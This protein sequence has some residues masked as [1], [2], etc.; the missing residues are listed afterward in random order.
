MRCIDSIPLWTVDRS[1]YFLQ[2]CILSSFPEFGS[3]G[4]CL[5]IVVA[6]PYCWSGF[7]T[8]YSHCW[9]SKIVG[10]KACEALIRES[11]RG[12]KVW[13]WRPD[14]TQSSS[15]LSD[16]FMCSRLMCSSQTFWAVRETW[17]HFDLRVS[18]HCAARYDTQWCAIFDRVWYNASLEMSSV[19]Y[20]TLQISADLCGEKDTVHHCSHC[21]RCGALSC[22]P[23]PFQRFSK[24]LL[25]SWLPLS[26]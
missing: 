16:R 2:G 7:E 18:C 20:V 5:M 12:Q 6:F 8:L 22:S 21:K 26:A 4:R 13:M 3:K 24:T 1:G 10:C 25:V 9:Q 23:F 11:D 19:Y 17:Q 15:D 14:E